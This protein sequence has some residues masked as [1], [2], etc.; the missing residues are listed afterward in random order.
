MLIALFTDIHGNRE[1]FEA[2]LADVGRRRIDR[3]IFLG[4]HVGYGADPGI[5]HRYRQGL[6]RARRDRARRQPRQR[7]ARHAGAD[8]RRGDA[9]DRMDTPATR[10][11]PVRIPARPAIHRAGRRPS[12]CARQ[13]RLAGEWE[14]VF[15]EPAAA[16]SLHATNADRTFC[17]HTHVPALFHL[18]ATGQVAAFDPLDGVAMPLT[19]HRRWVAVIGAVGQPRDG[20]PGRL[21]CAVR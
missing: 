20:N 5:R 8:E 7:R 13:R 2:C 15:D 18:T 21:L 12:L 19:W 9:G 4:D 17:G 10:P 6:C 14:Y 11:E 3:F 16:R 1:A